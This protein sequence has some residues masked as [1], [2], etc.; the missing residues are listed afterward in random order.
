MRDEKKRRTA[1]PLVDRTRLVSSRGGML[2]APA[3][4]RP[5]ARGSSL[6]PCGPEGGST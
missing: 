4:F 6:S 1:P 2:T 3:L 5:G